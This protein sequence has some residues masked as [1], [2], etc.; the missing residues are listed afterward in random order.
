MTSAESA[1]DNHTTMTDL[2]FN[3]NE[4]FVVPPL[5][6]KMEEKEV[7]G[8]APDLI[9]AMER[10]LFGALNNAWMLAIGGIGLMSV[11]HGD[12]NATNVGVMTLTGGIVLA[13]MSFITHVWRAHLLSHNRPLTLSYSVYRASAIVL[14]VL[15]ALTFEL[16][17]GILYP[18]LDREKAVTVV[19]DD[20]SFWN[21]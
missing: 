1:S 21:D 14:L 18:Y 11:G 8:P 20:D 10:T 3:V 15:L 7:V 19:N 12:A 17:Y 6:H 2:E 16:Y 13:I 5:E 9:M 4:N